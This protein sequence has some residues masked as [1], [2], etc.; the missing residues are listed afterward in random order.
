MSLHALCKQLCINKADK[1][2]LEHPLALRI[3]RPEYSLYA[4]ESKSFPN[5][6]TDQLFALCWHM[7]SD[8]TLYGNITP[9]DASFSYEYKY[10]AGTRT[11]MHTHEYLELAYI[12]SGNF[13][14]CIMGREI[15]FEKGDLCLIDMN[16]L[17]QD[18]LDQGESCILFLGISNNMFDQIIN[19]LTVEI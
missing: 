17:H 1:L 11:Q 15:V 19:H 9:T 5:I 8:L 10:A 18:F 7:T 6:A 12:V 4:P 14:Q 16:C 3:M 13:R 2:P